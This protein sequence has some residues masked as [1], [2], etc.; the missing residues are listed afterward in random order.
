MGG[1]AF[2]EVSGR[3]VANRLLLIKSGFYKGKF[4][5]LSKSSSC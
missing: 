3:I 4:K 1:P 2:L 5:F